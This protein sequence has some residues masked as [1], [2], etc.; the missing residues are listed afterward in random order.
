MLWPWVCVCYDAWS[1]EDWSQVTCIQCCCNFKYS[2]NEWLLTEVYLHLVQSGKVQFHPELK[3]E[4]P[5]KQT[6]HA[7]NNKLLNLITLT[8]SLNWLGIE[9]YNWYHW[10]IDDTWLHTSTPVLGSWTTD[11]Q[12]PTGNKYEQIR[13]MNPWGVPI[14]TWAIVFW[15]NCSFWMLFKSSPM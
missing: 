10:H 1:F 5:W 8:A 2:R 13:Y 4:N 6:V 9:T 7:M 11:L 14:T 3:L 12:K 15:T